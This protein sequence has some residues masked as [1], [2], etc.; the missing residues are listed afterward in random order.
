MRA[1]TV[2]YTM[3]PV[4]GPDGSCLGESS[5]WITAS[6]ALYFVTTQ[7]TYIDVLNDNVDIA[8]SRLCVGESWGLSPVPNSS[9]LMPRQGLCGPALVIYMQV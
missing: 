2:P 9:I 3:C 4:R 1:V 8:I 5:A 7:S 6:A